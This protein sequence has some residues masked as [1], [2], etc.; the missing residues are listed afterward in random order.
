[1]GGSYSQEDIETVALGMYRNHLQNDYPQVLPD[2]GIDESLLKYSGPD[3]NAALQA[4]SNEMLNSVPGYISGLGSAFGPL[5]SVPNAVGLGALVISMIIEIAIKSSTQKSDDD[6][7]SL[8]RRVFGE[9]K[10]SSVRDTMSEYL[11]RHRMSMNN[12]QLLREDIKRLEH[13]LSHHLTILR[14][15]L[16]QDGQMSSRGFKIWVNGAAFHVQML[17]HG[18]R[19]GVQ[20][21]E[22]A[23]DYVH[24]IKAAINMYLQYLVPLLKEHKTYKIKDG[25]Q[26]WTAF[27]DVVYSN[28]EP[29][30]GLKSYF[31]NIKYNLNSRIHE[32]GS[33]TLPSAAG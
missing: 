31:L 5:T 20:A 29:I 22:T 10:A 3:S 11:K 2:V 12:D 25:G 23:S 1:M 7:Y 4:F 24:Q 27:M 9:E 6:T 18:A 33:F 16:L 32:R 15:S 8:L 21:N 13:Q 28:Y 17:I 19:L 14:N 26:I 30:T